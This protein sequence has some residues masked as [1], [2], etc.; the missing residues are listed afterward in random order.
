M[1]ISNLAI[2]SEDE[3]VESRDWSEDEYVES[4]DWRAKTSM[5]SLAILGLRQFISSR[6]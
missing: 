5:S 6:I 4:R 2:E 1:S 3:Y